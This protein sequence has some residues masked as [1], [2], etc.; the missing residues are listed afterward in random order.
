MNLLKTSPDSSLKSRD[1]I[2]RTRLSID[3][4]TTEELKG[5]PRPTDFSLPT[6]LWDIGTSY[7]LIASRIGGLGH[8]LFVIPYRSLSELLSLANNYG[9][10]NE[11]FIHASNL[12]FVNPVASSIKGITVIV[13]AGSSYQISA[14]EKNFNRLSRL[15]GSAGPTQ[16]VNNT[17]KDH[18][19]KLVVTAEKSLKS[20]ESIGIETRYSL[21]ARVFRTVVGDS[22]LA[23]FD[24]LRSLTDLVKVAGHNYETNVGNKDRLRIHR[25]QPFGV[26]G[27]I[28]LDLEKMSSTGSIIPILLLI[29]KGN[30]SIVVSVSQVDS[31]LFA[32]LESACNLVLPPGVVHFIHSPSLPD[33][34]HGLSGQGKVPLLWIVHVGATLPKAADIPVNSFSK[35]VVDHVNSLEKS[36]LSRSKDVEIP[37]IIYL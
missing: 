27:L 34:V 23:D 36:F 33:A 4:K 32:S 10:E 18:F 29:L 9:D 26:A 3:S 2:K 6:L 35:V 5:Y 28:L 13:N 16:N 15:L 22:T 21:A 14:P 19:G 31:P 17:R 30:V 20:W 37:K 12:A 11:I 25:Y 24:R 7:D 8:V 1:F